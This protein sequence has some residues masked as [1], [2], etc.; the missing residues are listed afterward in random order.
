MVFQQPDEHR[1]STT[2]AS[3]AR[4]RKTDVT[5]ARSRA[6]RTKLD[7]Q[8]QAR[9]PHPGAHDASLR[10]QVKHLCRPDAVRQ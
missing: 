6:Q 4:K 9:K 8:A 5:E 2:S 3:K 7:E 1:S 10:E